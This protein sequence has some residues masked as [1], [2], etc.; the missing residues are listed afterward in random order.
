[1]FHLSPARQW[2]KEE[3]EMNYA[4]DELRKLLRLSSPLWPKGELTGIAVK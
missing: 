3:E 2:T 1:V 4:F